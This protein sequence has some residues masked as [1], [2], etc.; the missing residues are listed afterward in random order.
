LQ[1]IAVARGHNVSVALNVRLPLS[2]VRD[3][4]SFNASKHIL[5]ADST[6]WGRM[7]NVSVHI[8]ALDY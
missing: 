1:S 3:T 7:R 8:F 2:A 4:R 6:C 5:Q